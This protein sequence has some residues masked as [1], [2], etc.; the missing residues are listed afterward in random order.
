MVQ[1]VWYEDDAVKAQPMR[2]L[3]IMQVRGSAGR[4]EPLLDKTACRAFGF[5]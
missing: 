4:A 1:L 3:L 5:L 2:D